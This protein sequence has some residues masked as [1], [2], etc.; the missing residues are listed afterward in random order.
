MKL[1]AVSFCLI[2]SLFAGWSFAQTPTAALRGQ[3]SDSS[4]AM[5]PNAS[6][7]LRSKDTG[8]QRSTSTGSFGE[9]LIPALPPGQ[10]EVTASAPGFRAATHGAELLVG[11]E[12]TLNFRLEVGAEMQTVAVEGQAAQVNTTEFKVE[13][14]IGRSQVEN[15]PLNG[16]NAL[17]LARLQPGV[18]VSSGVPSGKNGFVS[19]GIGGETSAATRIT[20][21]GG[22]VVDMVTGGSEQ[23]FSQEVVQEFQVSVGN[24]DISTGISASGAVNIVT[25]SGTNHIHGTAFAFWRDSSFA[26]NPALT[27]NPAVPDPKFDREQYGYLASGPVIRDKLFW[28]TSV[29]WTRQRGVNPFLAN[30]LEFTAFNVIKKEPFDV[31]LQTHKLDWNASQ[32]DRVSFRFSRDGNQGRAGGSLVENQRLNRNGANQLLS[33]WTHVFGPKLVSDYRIQFQK[34]SNYYT[35]TP[36]AFALGI[37]RV[38]IRQSNVTFGLDDN[39]PQSTL[40]GRLE[41]NDT[42]SQ[43]VGRHSLKYG[44]SFERDRGRGTWQL[45]YPASITLYSPVEARAGGIAV[46]AVYNTRED[47]LQL[48]VHDFVFGYGS[49]E[50]PPFRPDKAAINHRARFFIGD[51]WKVKNHFTL[52][53]GIAYSFEDNLVNY[54]LD[55]PASLSKVLRGA[56]Q[57]TRRDWNNWAPQFGFAWAPGTDAKTVVRGG[58][59]IYYDTLQL[60]VRLIERTQLAPAGVGY[61]IV[62]Q[63]V[64]PDPANP[65]RSLNYLPL[66]PSSFRGADLLR[67]LS[68]IRTPFDSRAAASQASQDLS[69]RNIEN[70]Q[71]NGGNLLDPFLT[72]PYSMHYTLGAQRELARNLLVSVDG[73]FKQTV[74]ELFSADYN[75]YQSVRGSIDAKYQAVSFYQSG[76]TAQYKALL[77]RVEKRYTRRYQFLGS[78]ALASFN[79]LNGSG[80]F[81]GSS[82]SNKENWKDGFGPQG[83]DRRHRLVASAT[84]DLPWGFQVSGISE[85]T[86]RG[87]ANLTGGNYDYNGDGTRGDRIPGIG[88]NQVYRSIDESDLPRIVDQ[89]NAQYGGKKDAQGAVVRALPPLPSKY[90]LS[91]PTVSQDLRVSKSVR[92]GERLKILGIGEVFNILNIANLG[93]Y[94]GDLSSAT[95]GQPTN[96]VSN[97]FGSGGPRAFQLALRLSF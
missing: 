69:F 97:V 64:I 25:R 90:R 31:K 37:P 66:N 34:Y 49:P 73:E 48:P 72:T 59:G 51:S 91:E 74:H 50:Q 79:G 71:G 9:F 58:F 6:V 62:G 93:G 45:R 70:N 80:L 92:I 77:V 75:R 55:K 83:S 14:I 16:R 68:Q 81:L 94:S 47:L 13:G 39:S 5:I 19:V 33:N 22:S 7:A 89:F 78:Y 3:V 35:P 87:P 2:P 43:Q 24:P 30:N 15:M 42:F 52:S 10:Y 96:R 1:K 76:A 38:S 36:E 61:P 4:Q 56:I 27:R 21:D 18:L 40:N 11:R 95:F 12:T 65:S 85:A 32:T 82:V 54:D 57:P 53:F 29:D 26:A 17:E 60:N 67:Y 86:S 23:N 41:M 46:P 88:A 44:F 8:L 28:L 84:V 63:D 20:I